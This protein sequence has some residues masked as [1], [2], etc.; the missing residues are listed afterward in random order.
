MHLKAGGIRILII[1]VVLVAFWAFMFGPLSY[2]IPGKGPTKSLAVKTVTLANMANVKSNAP[3]L[4]LPSTDPVAIEGPTFKAEVMGWNAQFSWMLAN[5]GPQ[6]T[7]GSLMEKYGVAMTLECQNDCDQMKNDIIAF[8]NDLKNG[9][10]YPTANPAFV[11]IMGDGL[12]QFLASINPTLKKLGDGTDMYIA[13]AVGSSGYSFGEDALWGP[14][15]WLDNPASMKGCVI[16]GYLRDGDWNIA[17]KWIADHGIKNNPDETTYDPDAVNWIS[18][19]DYIDAAQKY[20]GGA[21]EERP[22]VKDGKKTGGMKKVTAEGVV[23]WTPGD[24]NIAEQKG[25]LI[26]VVSTRKYTGQMP[27]AI[28]GINT[29]MKDNRKFV[30]GMIRAIGEAGDQI[31]QYPTAKRRAAEVSAAVYKDKDADYWLRYH[32]GVRETDVTGVQ[33]D[34]GGSKPNNLADMYLLFGPSALLKS[35]YVAFGNVVVQQYPKL[36]PSF[37]PPEE[38]IDGSYVLEVVSETKTSTATATQYTFTASTALKE[39]VGKRKY[40]IQ[41]ATGSDRISGGQEDILENLKDELAVSISLKAVIHGHTDNV[42]NPESNFT[43]S[44]ARAASVK[45]WLETKYPDVFPSGRLAVVAHGQEKPI[46]DN[47]TSEGRS[48]N[49]RVE[50]VTGTEQ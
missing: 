13:S 33:V 19:K 2:L 24:V 27:Q 37:P 43:L 12:A 15:I 23:T 8:A 39:V 30:K 14:R 25:G 21:S 48:Q 35:T 3:E 10:A 22:I 42:G 26:Q 38:A 5:G 46:A 29:W 9:N 36:V 50:V 47:T 31:K 18:A 41:F 7:R 40:Q 20:I 17:M 32:D 28:V 49:R 11:A 45:R 6:T 1:V 16:A 34:L 44:R 4:P